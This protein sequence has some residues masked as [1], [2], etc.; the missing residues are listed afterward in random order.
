[1]KKLVGF[2]FG[3]KHLAYNA[4]LRKRR[5]AKKITQRQLSK[6][7]GFSDSVIGHIE[8]FRHWPTEKQKAILGSVLDTEIDI[9]F[10]KW[11]KEFKV[12]KS[13]FSTEHIITERLLPNIVNRLELTSGGIEDTV[14]KIDQ[15]ILADEIKNI[16]G[17]L[18]DRE[19]KVIKMRF[20]IGDDYILAKEGGVQKSHPNGATLEDVARAF[21]VTRERIRQMEAKALRKLKHPAIRRKLKE[22]LGIKE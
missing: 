7:C 3:V 8:G 12:K 13:S 21:G 20:G 5:E 6:I 19:A 10:P 4:E 11:M 22:M 1:M 16:L 14:E 9:L 15:E 2:S 18:T 17:H